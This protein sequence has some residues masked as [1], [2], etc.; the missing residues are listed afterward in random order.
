MFVWSVLLLYIYHHQ[1]PIS[2]GNN[3]PKST[4]TV[5]MRINVGHI[6]SQPCQIYDLKVVLAMIIILIGD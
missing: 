6:N 3:S 5:T 4:S 1:I 2:V